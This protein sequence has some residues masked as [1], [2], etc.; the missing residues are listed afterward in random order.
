MTTVSIGII[1]T[2]IPMQCARP[3]ATFR[4]RRSTCA[5][6]RARSLSVTVRAQLSHLGVGA[7]QW[8]FLSVFGHMKGLVCQ[9]GSRSRQTGVMVLRLGISMEPIGRH[10]R[11]ARKMKAKMAISGVGSAEG[12]LPYTPTVPGSHRAGPC[13]PRGAPYGRT[14]CGRSRRTQNE[15]PVGR[16]GLRPGSGC[17]NAIRGQPDSGPSA[18]W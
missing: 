8:A 4:S 12:H 11:M 18:I 2:L 13:G 6:R 9:R 15:S 3:R 17:E 16:K 7:I 10:G 5:G 14:E 1:P